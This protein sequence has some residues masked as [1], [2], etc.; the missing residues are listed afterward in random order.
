MEHDPL[1][2]ALDQG[3]HLVVLSPHL[4]DAILSCGA[5]IS[6]ARQTAPI[7]VVTFFTEAGPGPHTLSAK[8][9]LRQVGAVDAAGLYAARRTEDA[10]V[11]ERLGVGWL[12]LGMPEGLF[13]RRPLPLPVPRWAQRILPEVAHVYP[14]YRMH[15]ACGR[16]AAQDEPTVQRA[17]RAVASLAS[18]GQALFL[19]PLAVGG[20]ADHLIVRRAAEAAMPVAPVVHYSDFP[21][22]LTLPVDPAFAGFRHLYPRISQRCALEKDSL[23]RGYRT[24]VDALFPGGHI[25][26]APETYLYGRNADCCATLPSGETA[27]P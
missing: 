11:M 7:T 21:Y 8:R 12:H 4:D 18:R 24:Q 5:L 27:W 13:R 17:A 23:I 16:I 10:E 14:T 3:I 1:A 20:H 25:P 19:A 2:Q 6:H 22:N 9:Y 15:L 26:S